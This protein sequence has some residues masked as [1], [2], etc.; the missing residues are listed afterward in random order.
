MQTILDTLQLNSGV[1]ATIYIGNTLGEYIVAV[2]VLVGVVAILKLVQVIIIARL[3]ALSQRTKTDIDDTLV[4]MLDTIKPPLYIFLGIY[5]GLRILTIHS[6]VQKGLDILLLVWVVYQLILMAQVAVDFVLKKSTEK[7]GRENKNALRFLGNIGKTL[8]WAVGI[9]IILQNLGVNISALVAGL[10]IGGIAIALALQSILGDLFSSFSI[11]FDKPFVVGDVI[12]IGTTSGEVEKI[13]IKTT[14][15]R[16]PH[17]EEIIISNAE[18]TNAQIKN[19]GRLKERRVTLKFGVLYDTPKEKFE[20]IPDMIKGIINSV[21]NCRFHR[22]HFV[23]F[24]DSA[25]E[26]QVTYHIES[27]N[28]GIYLDRQQEVNFSV[29]NLFEKEGIGM[30]YPTQTIYLS[31]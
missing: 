16:S 9:L 19:L 2:G 30:A 15:I 26:F 12:K 5:T 20:K 22:A 28:Y 29:K 6:V 10:G 24:G 7:I 27:D 23:N 31:K 13:G 3:R 14:R 1:F 25:L 4:A 8:L 21:G 11:V 18:L 17:G